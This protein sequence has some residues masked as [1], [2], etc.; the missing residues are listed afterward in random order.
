M[1]EYDVKRFA[2]VSAVNAEIDGMKADN[3]IR[4]LNGL[5][6]CYDSSSF[7]YKANELRN[8]A[9]MHDHQL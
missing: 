1:T 9:A 5:I 6:P 2:L 7:E 4:E 3:N 8:I